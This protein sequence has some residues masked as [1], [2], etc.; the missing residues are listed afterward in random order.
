MACGKRPSG[1]PTHT[2][3]TQI[4]IIFHNILDP[5]ISPLSKLE[6]RKAGTAYA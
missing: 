2:N 6:N 4:L 3:N 5:L 1:A